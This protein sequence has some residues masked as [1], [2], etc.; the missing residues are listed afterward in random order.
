MIKKEII[1]NEKKKKENGKRN[2]ASKEQVD[3]M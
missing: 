3:S 1:R 2:K